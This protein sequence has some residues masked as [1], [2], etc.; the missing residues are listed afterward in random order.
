MYST[1]TN[2]THSPLDTP[3]LFTLA[4]TKMQRFSTSVPQEFIKHAIPDYLV[5]GTDLFS[6]RSSNKKI[7]TANTTITV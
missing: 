3:K 2:H 7:T 1:L 4:H 6:L 5:R